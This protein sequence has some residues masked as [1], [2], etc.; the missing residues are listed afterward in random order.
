MLTPRQPTA[1]PFHLIL[2]HLS[3]HPDFTS[4]NSCCRRS[5]F[6]SPYK[7]CHSFQSHSLFVYPYLPSDR[8]TADSLSQDHFGAFF[9]TNPINPSITTIRMQLLK[10]LLLVSA[11]LSPAFAALANGG[12]GAGDTEQTTSTRTTTVTVKVKTSSTP[13]PAPTHTSSSISTPIIKSATSTATPTPECTSFVITTVSSSTIPRSS[14]PLLTGS[15]PTSSASRSG[16]ATASASAS[17]S[18]STTQPAFTGAAVPG[19]KLSGAGAMGAGLAAMAF[20]L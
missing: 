2:I 10:T 6:L 20:M 16:T 15:V 5:F 19:A 4:N 7:D 14:T 12:T 17:A 13:P 8:S 3:S 1:A 18:A 11:A 9:T